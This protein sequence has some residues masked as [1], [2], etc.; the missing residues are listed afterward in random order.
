MA[1]IDDQVAALVK[2]LELP[3][4]W[5]E[6]LEEL[7]EHKEERQNI[8]GKRRY[9][10]GKIRRLREV[11]IDGDLDRAEYDQRRAELQT[12]LDALVV[13]DVPDIEAAGKTLESLGDVWEG[14]SKR[15]RRDMLRT[16][17]E[18]VYVDVEARQLVC[19]KP[20]PPFVLLFRMDGLQEKDG[21][22]YV[23]EKE[24]EA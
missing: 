18:A 3:N 12:E 23:E 7:A 14:A 21:C 9:L 2:R 11:Y 4:D 1:V 24:K 19:V 22:F 16:I 10:E 6:R 17:F 13:P 5:R 20:W 8:E 15:I